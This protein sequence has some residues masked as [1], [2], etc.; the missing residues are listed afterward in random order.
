MLDRVGDDLIEI[1]DAAKLKP[2]EAAAQLAFGAGL[3]AYRFDKYRTKQ[4][5]EQAV[6][7]TPPICRSICAPA[8]A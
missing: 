4:K 1:G 2:A 8:T 7:V 3:R 6:R 5:L